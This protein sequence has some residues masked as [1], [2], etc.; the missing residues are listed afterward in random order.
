MKSHPKTTMAYGK[1]GSLVNLPII[2]LL[3][4]M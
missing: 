2:S 3:V 1:N 4:V